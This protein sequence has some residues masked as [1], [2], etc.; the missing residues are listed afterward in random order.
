MTGFLDRV[1]AGET[2]DPGVVRSIAVSGADVVTAVEANRTSGRRTVLRV[3]PPFS[4]RM[5]ARLHVPQTGRDRSDEAPEPI[6]V[7]PEALLA[8]EAPPVP[9]PDDT[10]EGLRADP[11]REYTVERH[12]E[13]HARAMAGWRRV[14]QSYIVDS[15]PLPVPDGTREVD[16]VALG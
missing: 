2:S 11:D 8:D 16:V 4:G 14:A 6:H 13:R 10:A 9:R 3:T 7:D 12:R 5:R 1:V 15:V